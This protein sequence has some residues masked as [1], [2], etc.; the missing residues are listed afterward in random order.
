[1]SDGPG[2]APLA[3]GDESDPT[4]VK[5]EPKPLDPGEGFV[6]GQLI[7]KSVKAGGTEPPPEFQPGG[8]TGSV[9]VEGEG[10]AL[11]GADL[12]PWHSDVVSDY[13]SPD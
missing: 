5:F 12:G 8:R 9:I 10:G 7:G 2:T 11:I 13:F 1:V 4:K 3:F 6:P